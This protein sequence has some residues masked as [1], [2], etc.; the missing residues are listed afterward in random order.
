MSGLGYFLAIII[1][2][3]FPFILVLIVIISFIYDLLGP[4]Y[5]PT[6]GKLIKDI[7]KKSG[8]KKGEV[9]Y[10]LGSGDGRVTMIAAKDFE[11]KAVGVEFN[12]VLIL[13]SKFISRIKNVPNAKFVMQDL[14]KTDLSRADVI[15]LFLLPSML[16][17]LNPKLLKECKKGTVIVSHGFKIPD[18]EAKLKE[19]IDARPFPTYFYKL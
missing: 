17:K 10:E 6:S 5:V 2:V 8:L 13:Y 16:K 3:I 1:G 11:A 14:Y 9:F 19:K 7:L 15:F 18:F 12:P 4:P